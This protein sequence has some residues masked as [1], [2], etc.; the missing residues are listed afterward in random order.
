MDPLGPQGYDGRAAGK[1]FSISSLL[2]LVKVRKGDG[3]TCTDWLTLLRAEV[4]VGSQ[5]L[6]FS[7][8]ESYFAGKG[9]F[10]EHPSRKNRCHNE[11][12]SLSS[13]ERILMLMPLCV[14]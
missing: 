3:G 2:P 14:S 4:M 11:K 9:E 7:R 12:F 5:H 6:N 10:P 1:G 13:W 8:F